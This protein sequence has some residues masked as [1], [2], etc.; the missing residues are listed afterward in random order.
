MDSIENHIYQSTILYLIR[1]KF[2]NNWTLILLLY[3]LNHKLLQSHLPI[4]VRLIQP[5]QYQ[6]YLT[7]EQ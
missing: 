6:N 4:D 3:T 7:H 1:I 5:A 2:S